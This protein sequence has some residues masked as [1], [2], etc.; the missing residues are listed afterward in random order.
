MSETINTKKIE[1]SQQE[2]ELLKRVFEAIEVSP[3]EYDFFARTGLSLNK[4]MFT[5]ISDSE[6]NSRLISDKETVFFCCLLNIFNNDF[7]W[8]KEN[9][10]PQIDTVIVEKLLQKFIDLRTSFYGKSKTVFRQKYPLLSTEG[11]VISLGIRIPALELSE[12]YLSFRISPKTGR[13]LYYLDS[14]EVCMSS[15]DIF[16]SEIRQIKDFLQNL[17]KT[18]K[19]TVE[20]YTF[21]GYE[22]LY[23]LEVQPCSGAFPFEVD[24]NEFQI[25]FMFKPGKIKQPSQRSFMG[26]LS[27]LTLDEIYTA[28]Q[29]LQALLE[30]DTTSSLRSFLEC[31]DRTL[32]RRL[33]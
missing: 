5:R 12:L 31:S 23:F 26:G 2:L 21:R 3:G 4:E 9:V 30:L 32:L 27:V 28:I 22:N 29:S 20:S 19:E 14:Q 8:I 17:T 16:K 1:L 11:V 10:R 25:S 7:D 15:I 6:S 13:K 33:G 24:F 18:N